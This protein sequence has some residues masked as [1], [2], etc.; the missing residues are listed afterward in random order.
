M[1]ANAALFFF[2]SVQHAGIAV[3]SFHEPLIIPAAIV[4]TL[5]GLCLLWGAIALFRGSRSRWRIALITNLFALGGVFLGIAALAAG[6]GP[7]RASNDLYHRMMLIL[8]G[9]VILILSFGRRRLAQSDDRAAT[10][11]RTER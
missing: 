2:R 9:T 1:S 8:I 6:A 5:C 10:K 11:M 3:G 4:E 7:R